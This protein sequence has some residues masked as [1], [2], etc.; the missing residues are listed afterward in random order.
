MS[1]SMA[2]FHLPTCEARARSVVSLVTLGRARK[3]MKPTD[4]NGLLIVDVIGNQKPV[5][6]Y[7]TGF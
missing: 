7:P 1:D 4:S 5:G 3:G 6:V 2:G